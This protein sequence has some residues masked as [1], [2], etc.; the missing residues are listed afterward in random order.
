M[1]SC[2]KGSNNDFNQ[3]RVYT[4]KA[5]DLMA[6]VV[7][8]SVFFDDSDVGCRMVEAMAVPRDCHVMCHIEE[9]TEEFFEKLCD[10]LGLVSHLPYHIHMPHFC[11]FL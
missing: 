8:E 7:N 3:I 2:V 4:G 11:L 9:T 1:V 6:N 10:S 5:F